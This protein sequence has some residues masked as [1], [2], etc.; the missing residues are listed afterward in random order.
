VVSDED[1]FVLVRTYTDQGEAH[2][3]KH[4]LEEL[5]ISVILEGVET[6]S[7]LGGPYAGTDRARLLVLGEQAARAAFILDDVEARMRLPEGWEDAAERGPVCTLCG[8]AL[9]EDAAEC[10]AC[11]TPRDAVR[12]PGRR[13]PPGRKHE[14]PASEGVLAGPPPG[15]EEAEAPPPLPRGPGC[16]W[17]LLWWLP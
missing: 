2:L 5:G 6:A 11:R 7:I 17:L 16:L 4:M 1:R 8:E 14:G 9:G 13:P 10:P 15:E 12:A 3:A